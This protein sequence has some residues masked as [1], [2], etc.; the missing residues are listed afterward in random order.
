MY[1]HIGGEL[2][3]LYRSG[4]PQLQYQGTTASMTGYSNAITYDLM[5][6]M[7]SRD[8]KIRPFVSAGAGIK[9]YTGSGRFALD[10]PLGSYAL[11]V[12]NTQ[13]EPAI[14]LGAGVKWLV[15]KRVQLRADFRVYMTPL[16]NE[17]FRPTGFSTIHGWIYDFVPQ[18]GVSYV[19]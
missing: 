17:I 18:V 19:F 10:Q 13:V 1:E 12:R 2:R 16:P 3:Y 7:T 14:D 15:A 9:V 11:L 6:H 8:V 4:G 5:I